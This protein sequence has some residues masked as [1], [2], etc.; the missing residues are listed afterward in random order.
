MR[1][2]KLFR[3]QSKGVYI[4]PA[5]KVVYREGVQ[6]AAKYLMLLKLEVIPTKKAAA[7][8]ETTVLPTPNPFFLRRVHFFSVP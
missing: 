1:N 5:A 8:D 6:T 7:N 3:S 2:E 4:Y